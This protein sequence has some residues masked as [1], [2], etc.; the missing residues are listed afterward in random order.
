MEFWIFGLF[1][2]ENQ[3]NLP[4][5]KET[6]GRFGGLREADGAMRHVDVSRFLTHHSRSPPE[7]TSPPLKKFYLH[8]S[9]KPAK[10]DIAFRI[11]RKR[12]VKL[13]IRQEI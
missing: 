3:K 12:Q 6:E 7:K 13:C 5:G 9:V 11:Y 10:M 1:R 8:F 2:G 4:P